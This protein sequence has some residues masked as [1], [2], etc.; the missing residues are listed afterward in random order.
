MK[1]DS[2][3]SAAQNNNKTMTVRIAEGFY[4]L[5]GRIRI[6]VIMLYFVVAYL[7]VAA[8]GGVYPFRKPVGS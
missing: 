2:N 1:N 4:A 6:T 8:I 5:P 7:I 3:A